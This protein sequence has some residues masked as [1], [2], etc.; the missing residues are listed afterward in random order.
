MSKS[1]NTK[2]KRRNVLVDEVGGT[3]QVTYSSDY[4]ENTGF[5]QKI[6]NWIKRRLRA[7]VE[8][9]V[10]VG[11]A[12]FVVVQTSFVE[13]S[14]SDEINKFFFY[15]GLVCFFS[16]SIIGLF[17]SLWLKFGLGV[18]VDDWEKYAPRS[19]PAATLFGVLSFVF[20]IIAYWPAYSILTPFI[21]GI[22]YWGLMNVLV[23]LPF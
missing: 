20:F 4:E 7:W 22:L 6:I 21:L 2:L 10:F 16:S 15:V 5:S 9:L 23:L 17:F 12:Y 18:D 13:L 14:M 8:S 19:V 3:E 1:S 11:I